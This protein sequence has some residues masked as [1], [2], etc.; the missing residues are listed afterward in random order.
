[1]PTPKISVIIPTFNRASFLSEAIRSVLEQD[2][3]RQCSED[4]CTELWVIDDGST[5]ETKK[6]V[7]T[8]GGRLKYRFQP[9]RGVSA[10]R[11]LGLRLASGRFIAFLDSDDLWLSNKLLSQMSYMEAYPK[12]MICYTEEVWVRN[13]RVVNPKKKHK[14]YSGWILR[15]LQQLYRIM[16]LMNY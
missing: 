3:F 6:V 7:R 14:K 13:G 4:S 12:S 11:N 16:K 2:Y 9:N 1:M 15:L 10:A 8:F 5:D